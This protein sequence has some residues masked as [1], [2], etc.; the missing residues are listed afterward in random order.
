[1]DKPDIS[2]F[3]CLLLACSGAPTKHLATQRF[4][5]HRLP[6]TSDRYS[7][8]E[9]KQLKNPK[10][11]CQGCFSQD[12][13]RSEQNDVYPVIPTPR[14]PDDKTSVA[15]RCQSC[16]RRVR[17]LP[18]YSHTHPVTPVPQYE[19]TRLLD[20]TSVGLSIKVPGY[21]N[22]QGRAA[23]C[24]KKNGIQRHSVGD[25]YK[26]DLRVDSLLPHRHGQHLL[27]KGFR[28]PGDGLAV[29]YPVYGI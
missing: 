16:A 5:T 7:S 10:L 25:G 24:D 29:L 27:Q 1:M 15:T 20:V 9:G 4:S 12:L 8:L 23:L 2:S 6:A 28:Q 18:L 14:H 17:L 26:Q 19:D 22:T 21:I 11:K 13:N 3:V